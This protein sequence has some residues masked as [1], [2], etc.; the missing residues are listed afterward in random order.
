MSVWNSPK[1]SVISYVRDFVL[2]GGHPYR[3]AKS[4][5]KVQFG[6]SE[7]HRLSHPEQ[8]LETDLETNALLPYVERKLL[9]FIL[10]K[11]HSLNIREWNIPQKQ[12][13]SRLACGGEARIRSTIEFLFCWMRIVQSTLVSAVR[14][15]SASLELLQFVYSFDIC[16]MHL[17]SLTGSNR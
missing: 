5:L 15:R 8:R 10:Q 1:A 14:K 16:F 13:A 9:S 7:N 6:N 11:T 2:S 17:F 4:T 12:L 3:S